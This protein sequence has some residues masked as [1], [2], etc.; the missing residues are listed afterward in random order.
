MWHFVYVSLYATRTR[1]K[2]HQIC[3][4]IL[5]L[6][7]CSKFVVHCC[8]F[9]FTVLFCLR[10]DEIIGKSLGIVWTTII[11]GLIFVDW[12]YWVIFIPLWIWKSIAT[13]G[14]IVGAIV[15]CRYPHYR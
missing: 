14:A 5:C 12:P 8:L 13:L 15:W 1:F 11:D 4:I 3:L 2:C 9:T 7:S 6:S 10:L